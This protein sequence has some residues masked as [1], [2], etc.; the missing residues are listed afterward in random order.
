MR[1]W[2]RAR[3][4]TSPRRTMARSNRSVALSPRGAATFAPARPDSAATESFPAAPARPDS[5]ATE[6]FPPTP[7]RP[8]SP[9]A[10][11]FPR[12]VLHAAFFLASF[13]EL[14]KGKRSGAFLSLLI[15]DQDLHPAL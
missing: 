5:A 10:E 14:L 1:L 4:S 7:P 15:L 12:S 9:T 6:S 11:A 8:H 13:R 2:A 3:L